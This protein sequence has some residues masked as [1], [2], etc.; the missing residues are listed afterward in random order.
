[1]KSLF[2]I[3]LSFLLLLYPANYAYAADATD[4][5]KVPD[6]CNFRPINSADTLYKTYA[7]Q[8]FKNPEEI[9][10][11]DDVLTTTLTVKYGDNNIAGCPVHLRSYNGKLVGPTLRVKPGDTIRITLIN[12]LPPQDHPDNHQTNQQTDGDG[13]CSYEMETKTKNEPHDFNVT[14]FH[15]HGLHVSPSG[16]SDNVLRVMKPRAKEGEPAKAY[17]IEVKVPK[18]HPTGTY[19]YHA[20][21]HGSTALQVSSGMAGALIV[22]D[23]EEDKIPEIKDAEEKIFVVQQIVYDQKGEIENYGKK[24][25][26]ENYGKKEEIENYEPFGPTGWQDSKRH[27]TINGQI[28]PIIKMRPGEVQRWRFIHAG[29]RESIQ[30]ELRNDRV[31]IPL[32]E[33]A[34]DGIALGK[35]DSWKNS[36]VELEPGYRSD[37]LI[38]AEMLPDNKTEQ[39]YLLSDKPTTSK[40]SLLGVAETGSILAKVIVEGQPMDMKLPSDDQLATF[41]AKN[42]PKDIQPSE[43]TG[44]PQEVIFSIIK[45]TNDES[46]NIFKVNNAP[47]DPKNV[48]NLTLGKVE[49]W[50][51]N[52]ASD[53]LG[54]THPFHIHVNPFQVDRK[55]PNGNKERIWRDTLL[56]EKNE[57]Q[58][59]Y[60]RYTRF[61]G[62]FVLH[63]HILDHEDQGMMEVV[64]ILD[65]Q[66]DQNSEPKDENLDPEDKGMMEAVQIS[67]NPI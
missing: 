47:F 41:K 4:S 11:N 60:S 27:V 48:R 39:V 3:L 30:L 44:K 7:E 59:V 28:V 55:D 63:C 52:T 12:D 19:W 18:D 5:I 22:E 54:P 56:I 53:S 38:K 2:A 64:Q 58:T 29:I 37:V 43:I 13:G 15:T 50:E 42:A 21:L 32:H 51:L 9:T 36:P 67:H 45:D 57:T 16:C 14:N 8:D 62:K 17:M 35:L 46:K 25:E 34:V 40:E 33:I 31:Q 65:P 1:M 6:P 66:K 49:S 61:T 23:K 24:E 10:S 26:I 20:H